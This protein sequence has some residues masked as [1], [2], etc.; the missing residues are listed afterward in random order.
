MVTYLEVR[1]LPR[2]FLGTS[3]KSHSKWWKQDLNPG[4]PATKVFAF[5]KSCHLTSAEQNSL[6]GQL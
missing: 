6:R 4:L 5:N 1:E 3:L 2:K